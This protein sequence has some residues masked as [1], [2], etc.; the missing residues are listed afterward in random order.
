VHR[1]WDL[2]CR[3]LSHLWGVGPVVLAGQHVYGAVL[4][5]DRSYA[6]TSV[7]TSKVE[8]EVAVEDLCMC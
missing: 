6:R 8:V 1:S 4:G 2:V 7:P 5:I 3:L